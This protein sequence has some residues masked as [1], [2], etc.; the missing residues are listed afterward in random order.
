[1]PSCWNKPYSF[2]QV[3]RE[4]G[5]D[6]ADVLFSSDGSWKV[7]ADEDVDPSQKP[8]GAHSGQQDGLEQGEHKRLQNSVTEVVD[9]THEETED[10]NRELGSSGTEALM[11]CANQRFLNACDTDDRKPFQDTFD[12]HFVEN[13][14]E[15][16]VTCA[17]SET[18]TEREFWSSILSSVSVPGEPTATATRI[19]EYLSGDAIISPVLT[20]AVSPALSQEPMDGHGTAQSAINIH[21]EQQAGQ[22]LASGSVQFQL[23]QLGNSIVGTESER[24]SIPRHV[25]RVPVA[26]QALPAQRQV[27]YSHHSRPRITAANLNPTIC[28]GPIPGVLQ[29]T[30]SPTASQSVFNVNQDHEEIF[31]VPSHSFQSF[32]GSRTNTSQVG[33]RTTSEQQRAGAFGSSFGFSPSPHNAYYQRRPNLMMP[34]T[35]NQHANI[36]QQFSYF[37]SLQ[38]SGQGV[39]IPAASTMDHHSRHMVP[40]VN[41]QLS[42]PPVVTS[43]LQGTRS[44]YVTPTR[45]ST[46]EHQRNLV[47]GSHP[48][49]FSESSQEHAVEN[50]RPPVRMR[51]SLTGR[52]YSA[53]LNEYIIQPTPSAPPRQPI[54]TMIPTTSEQL[55]VLMSNNINSQLGHP[56]AHSASGL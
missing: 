5:P 45:L 8:S 49:S 4:V 29:T 20:D 3:L 34:Q 10:C 54:T 21:N 15:L 35:L 16:G 36:V 24:P 2:D 56:Q 30:P 41:S 11:N 51:G 26:V 27:P 42:R 52:A 22:T 28:S 25:D 9:L 39:A 46:G 31:N 40:P 43:Q 23:S 1:M 53:A 17:N 48:I 19:D 50:W 47:G 7:V 14:S 38:L 44:S 32:V 6:V 13:L 55:Q 33:T 37:P 12:F 18:G